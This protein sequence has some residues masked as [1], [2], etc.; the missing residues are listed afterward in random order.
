MH[1]SSPFPAGRLTNSMFGTHTFTAK[2][3]NFRGKL[4]V[5]GALDHIP[6]AAST[7]DMYFPLDIDGTTN[8][9]Q[10]GSVN[11][12]GR[13]GIFSGID[14]WSFSANVMWIMFGWVA[15]DDKG[16]PTPTFVNPT[17]V[18]DDL[19]VVPNKLDRVELRS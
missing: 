5:F 8:V 12:F 9:I 6:P 3:D 14:A 10:F 18:L 17:L 4:F 16:V 13:Y 11:E 15:T 2:A 19:S 1:Y 7:P